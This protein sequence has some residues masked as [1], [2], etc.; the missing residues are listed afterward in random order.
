VK[1][2]LIA[3]G[4]YQ[5]FLRLVSISKS[6]GARR[7]VNSLS[8]DV[9]GGEIFC[10][11]GPSGCGKTTLLRMIAGLE[12]PD[13]GTI[14]LDGRL[15]VENGKVRLAPQQRRIGIVFQDLALWPHLTVTGH[16]NFVLRSQGIAR[17][18][19]H[20]QIH[21]T[22]QFVHLSGFEAAYPETLSGGEQQRLAI[23]RAL[24][25]SP[26]LILLDEPLSSLDHQLKQDLRR[27]LV[28]WLKQLRTTAI[29]I[30]HDPAEA[31]E[32][33]DRIAIMKDGGLLN[34]GERASY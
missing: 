7:I 1:C 27:E 19:R 8:L 13:S 25:A 33:A 22:L 16:L 20:G 24:I 14:E 18:A 30:T 31:E 4:D 26:R 21:Q 29:W 2:I 12:T 9:Y 17:Q 15:A 11:L 5:A 10:V 23:A 34:V 32:A 28:G 6:F 3:M